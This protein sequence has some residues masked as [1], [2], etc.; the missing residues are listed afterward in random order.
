MALGDGNV[1]GLLEEGEICGVSVEEESEELAE[2]ELERL[3]ALE[4]CAVPACLVWWLGE[5][6]KLEPVEC[7][8]FVA[9]LKEPE[10]S[11]C[12]L[13]QRFSKRRL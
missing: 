9:V 5:R 3:I 10:G 1:D 13:V 12:V 4:G 6:D 2:D 7:I 8:S 11:V